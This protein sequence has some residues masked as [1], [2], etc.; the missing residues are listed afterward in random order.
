LFEKAFAKMGGSYMSLWAGNSSN[1]KSTPFIMLSGGVGHD[2]VHLAKRD[3]ETWTQLF[4]MLSEKSSAYGSY[5]ATVSA[6]ADRKAELENVG[7]VAFHAYSVIKCVELQGG[8]V[9]LIQCRNPW[10]KHEW[11]GAWSDD[12]KEW[13]EE[14]L[15]EL[16]NGSNTKHEF[17]NDGCFFMSFDDFCHIWSDFCPVHAFDHDRGMKRYHNIGEW[18]ETE[19]TKYVTVTVHEDN[20]SVAIRMI[21]PEDTYIE[22]K[23]EHDTINITICES[24]DDGLFNNQ[25]SSNN[26]NCLNCSIM[27]TLP[28]GT[29]SIA[30]TGKDT[31]YKRFA[32]NVFGN[33]QLTVS[34]VMTE[35]E[36]YKQFGYNTI[37]TK[38]GV[39][40]FGPNNETP[41]F[42]ITVE[43]ETKLKISMKRNTSDIPALFYL[44]Q[45]PD[46]SV[47]QNSPHNWSMQ[48]DVFCTVKAGWYLVK[49]YE[50]KGDKKHSEYSIT[51]VAN[52]S[53]TLSDY[54][55]LDTITDLDLVRQGF[56]YAKEQPS[57]YIGIEVANF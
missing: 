37:V 6:P 28:K 5:L 51:I 41:F 24:K 31:N 39:W 14:L 36:M 4:N 48:V 9:K 16:N 21:Q 30:C 40:E 18:T 46:Q 50:N 54:M 19:K 57:K 27:E 13:T 25:I 45:Y 32:V 8:K 2:A 43:T 11:K 20:T 26:R 49:P 17:K 12:S 42:L 15:K 29:Y 23:T 34:N 52:G 3:N 7:I 1:I 35:P 44:M 53:A 55:L 38:K 33:K 56:K 47:L 22:N 10:G